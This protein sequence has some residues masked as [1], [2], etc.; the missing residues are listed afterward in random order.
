MRSLSDLSFEASARAARRGL[1]GTSWDG[2]RV[3]GS[4]PVLD[5]G[6]LSER[7]AILRA[8]HNIEIVSELRP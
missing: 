8:S 4:D 1:N 5:F 3:G 6:L 7:R 2:K